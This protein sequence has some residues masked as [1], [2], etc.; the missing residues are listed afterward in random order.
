MKKFILLFGLA[1]MAGTYS[2][3]QE[4]EKDKEI[5]SDMFSVG[6]IVSDGLEIYFIWETFEFSDGKNQ[7]LYI[8]GTGI[9]QGPTFTM[10]DNGAH[11]IKP[12]GW[13]GAIGSRSYFSKTKMG[14]GFF[15]ANE[16]K[17]S[18]I[19]Y[20][21]SRFS[22]RYSYFSFFTPELGWKVMFGKSKSFGFEVSGG[23]EWAIEIKGK[24]DVD[25]K[26]FDNWKP[27]VALGFALNF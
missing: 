14:R 17:Y 8:K 13:S 10:Y 6:A 27:K 7:S 4:E 1:F 16:F 24:G 25:N 20:K 23:A 3:S 9:S 11:E 15:Y 18:T 2:F 26:N 12:E 22:G 21:D 5:P 19:R